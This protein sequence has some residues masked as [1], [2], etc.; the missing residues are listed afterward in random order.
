M[1]TVP[2]AHQAHLDGGVLTDKHLV[3]ITR[4]DG[5]IKRLTD[6][7]VDIEVAA[8]G[9]YTGGFATVHSLTWGINSEPASMDADI[10]VGGSSPLSESDVVTGYYNDATVE[11][12]LVNWADP[13]QKTP[14]FIGYIGDI[15]YDDAGGF[16]FQFDGLWSRATMMR[17]RTVGPNCDTELGHPTWCKVPIRPADDQRATAYALGDHVRHSSDGSITGYQN[18]MFEATGA[19]TTGASAPSWNYTVGATT[20]DGSVTWTAREAWIRH[21][22]VASVISSRNISITVTEPRA[23]DDW[24]SLGAGKWYSGNNAG[25]SFS[26]RKWEASGSVLAMWEKPR[27]DVQVG[28]L[29]EIYAGCNLTL[30]HCRDKFANLEHFMGFP[31][32]VDLPQGGR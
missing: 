27:G 1:R 9:T 15:A 5:T 13:T 11:V 12:S 21:A 16:K 3:K 22:T 25:N 26:I 30:E 17:M 19:G 28:D 20:T 18:I 8:D 14:L 4:R 7:D 23:V 6:L 24:F 32:L 31:Q 2:G 29:M 10:L